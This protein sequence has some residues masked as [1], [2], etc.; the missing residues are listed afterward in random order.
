M[1][2][3]AALHSRLQLTISGFLVILICWGLISILRGRF[4][5]GYTAGL[6]IAQLLLI[7]QSIL[8]VLSLLW[9]PN[10]IYFALHSIYGLIIVAVLPAT[11]HYTQQRT[12]KREAILLTG[13][14]LMVL[15]MVLRAFE[16]AV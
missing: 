7:A 6:W 5:N 12:G 11:L 1:E 8:G 2:R 9:V 15:V 3:L 14:C 4:G 10:P 16:T 13:I